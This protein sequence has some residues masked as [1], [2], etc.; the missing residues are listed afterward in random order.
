MHCFACP[1]SQTL[2]LSFSLLAST[3]TS[4]LATYLDACLPCLTSLGSWMPLSTRPQPASTRCRATPPSN[5]LL[6]ERWPWTTQ[7]AA[8]RECCTSRCTALFHLPIAALFRASGLIQLANTLRARPFPL[9]GSSL[10]FTHLSLPPSLPLLFPSTS[11]YSPASILVIP[12]PS[13]RPRFES[14]LPLSVATATTSFG[15]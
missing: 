6:T 15:G 3:N 9:Y 12:P 14:S 2:A 13:L 11:L 10:V 7:A 5:G 1:T 4:P 8:Q